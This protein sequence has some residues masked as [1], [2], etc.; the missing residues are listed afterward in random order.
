MFRLR[1]LW[2]QIF[3]SLILNW[4]IGPFVG[5]FDTVSATKLTL[6]HAGY[7]VG[8]AARPAYI[9]YRSDHGRVGKVHIDLL[10]HSLTAGAS[11]WS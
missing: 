10:E 8:N 7:C 1:S 9:S 2:K 11:Q 5:G 4:I 3:I 6:G